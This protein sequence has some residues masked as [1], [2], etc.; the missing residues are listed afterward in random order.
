M[1]GLDILK[2]KIL[3]EFETRHQKL[4]NN[5][6][7]MAVK[8]KNYRGKEQ[9]HTEGDKGH[10]KQRAV[11]KPKI[12]C[13]KCGRL[14]HRVAVC[15]SGDTN[16]KPA[17]KIVNELYY[18]KCR[19]TSD[20]CTVYE[21]PERKYWCLDS[22]CTTHLCKDKSKFIQLQPS[23]HEK[24][25][26]ASNASTNVEAKG[27][28]YIQTKLDNNIKQINFGDA[29]YVPDLRVNLVSVA[30]ITEKGNK[31]IFKKDAAIVVGDDGRIQ[32]KAN[33]IGDLYYIRE[34]REEVRHVYSPSF[35]KEPVS[36]M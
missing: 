31:V 25:N 13:F 3:E 24:L 23:T 11:W 16:R 32:L 26:L 14:E 21:D 2:V 12:K 1:P 7:A 5:H 22:G 18:A 34:E 30:K 27:N 10:Q 8:P 4:K 36:R 20:A 6:G 17:V 9:I 35:K 19:A 29:L 28:V 15:Y 33:K